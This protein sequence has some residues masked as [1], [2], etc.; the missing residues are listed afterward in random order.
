MKNLILLFIISFGGNSFSQNCFREITKSEWNYKFCLDTNMTFESEGA[1]VSIIQYESTKNQDI[2]SRVNL[3]FGSNDDFS[4]SDVILMRIGNKHYLL[5]SFSTTFDTNYSKF[6][7][8]VSFGTIEFSKKN[9]K[10]ETKKVA[11]VTYHST[12]FLFEFVSSDSNQNWIAGLKNVID[13]SE[14]FGTPILT[15]GNKLEEEFKSNFLACIK[16]SSL[17]D[18]FLVS[19]ELFENATPQEEKDLNA[20]NNMPDFNS[21]IEKWNNNM[22]N[23]FKELSDLDSV[24]ISNINFEREFFDINV[25]GYNGVIDL[26][27]N[28]NKISYRFFAFQF[29]DKIYMCDMRKK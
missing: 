18:D 10:L 4:S 13:R 25:I 6:N 1:K 7:I 9:G 16:D 23:T 22:K 3:S 28:S 12:Y 21:M 19:F 15:N 8:E 24:S 14:F 17:I 27:E 5:D 20:S 26:A 2:Q 11:V 29:E